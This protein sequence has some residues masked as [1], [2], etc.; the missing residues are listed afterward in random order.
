MSRVSLFLLI[1]PRELTDGYHLFLRNAGLKTVISFPCAGTAG[2]G[3]R[4]RLGLERNEKTLILS[5]MGGKAAQRLMDHCV[6]DMGLNLPGNGIALSVPVQAAGGETALRILTD[7]MPADAKEVNPMEKNP[8]FPYSLVVAICENGHSDEVMNAARSEGAAGGTVV[9][10]KG[11]AG[12]MAQKFLGVSLANEKE[13]ILI[14]T[15]RENR[16]GIMH[17]VMDQAGIQSKAHTILFSLPVESIAGLRNLT[18]G[19]PGE[20]G[21]EAP[22]A[23]DPEENEPG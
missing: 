2:A 9:H 5:M 7:N 10:A 4:A 14:L 13:L 20:E 6:T 8:Q 23:A 15:G 19:D 11:T 18:S 1:I 3:I 21:K 17:A 16:D 22:A 12:E